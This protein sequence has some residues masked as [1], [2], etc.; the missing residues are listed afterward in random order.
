VEAPT[1]LSG[2]LTN[3]AATRFAQ[4][5]AMG[6]NRPRP[7]AL[8]T[9]AFTTAL[10][11][12]A[13]T[14][15]P[16]SFGGAPTVKPDY[17]DTQFGINVG[18]PFRIPFVIKYGPM[19]QVSYQ[20][21]VRHNAN[22]VSGLVP[23]IAQRDGDF[24]GF[25]PIRDPRTG[26]PFADNAIPADRIV[27]QSLALLAYYP[28]PNGDTSTGGNFQRPVVSDTTSDNVNV[29]MSRNL[30]V[31]TQL[32][33]SFT[34]ARSVWDSVN[35]FD[36]T[37]RTQQSS[38]GGSVNDPRDLAPDVRAR[39]YQ[40]TSADTTRRFFANYVNVSGDAGIAGND[41]DRSTGDRRRSCFP[42]SRSCVTGSISATPARRTSSAARSDSGAAVTTSRSAA[43]RG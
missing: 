40:F 10:G 32:S 15:Q 21:G 14:A 24:S 31:R 8:Y 16:Y 36:F 4:P 17:A 28:V 29:S 25:A 12:S 38:F 33:G 7:P 13:W 22:A 27:P 26:Q 9:G 11:N 18:G 20:H 37:D 39:D 43:T 6:N 19:M 42:T 41:Q 5:R 30:G 3:G 23:T 2:S 34:Y 1:I 35:L